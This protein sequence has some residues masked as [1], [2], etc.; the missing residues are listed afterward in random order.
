[1]S[2]TTKNE[3]H[4]WNRSNDPENCKYCYMKKYNDFENNLLLQNFLRINNL[5]GQLMEDYILFM[6]N[7]L[8]LLS[9]LCGTVFFVGG[10]WSFNSLRK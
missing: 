5:H 3:G 10:L 8:H 4:V 9:S 6:Y 1:M 7:E 2:I